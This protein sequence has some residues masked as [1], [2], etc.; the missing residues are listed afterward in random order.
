MPFPVVLAEPVLFLAY[1]IPLFVKARQDA[2][3]LGGGRHFT[4]NHN[5]RGQVVTG[6]LRYI[7]IARTQP[8]VFLL[9]MGLVE[10]SPKHPVQA[11]IV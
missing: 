3:H 10:E 11:S 6:Q 1:A 7:H 4:L 9:D 8:L 5:L 2:G